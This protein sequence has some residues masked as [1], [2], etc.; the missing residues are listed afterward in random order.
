MQKQILDLIK[1]NNIP[2]VLIRAEPTRLLQVSY[3]RSDRQFKV[4]KGVYLI[5]YTIHQNMVEFS[6]NLKSN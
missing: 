1:Q 2:L 6:V 5:T 4:L 3:L